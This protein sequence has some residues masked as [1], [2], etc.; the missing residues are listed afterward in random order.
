MDS[1]SGQQ[2]GSF[3]VGELIGAGGM[4]LI[5][6]AFQPSMGRPVA[7]KLLQRALIKQDARFLERFAREAQVAASLTHPHIVPVYDYGEHAGQPYLVMALLEGGSL[8]DR[9]QREGPLDLASSARIVRA[10]GSALDFAHSQGVIHRDVKPDNVVFDLS[11]NP[12]LADFG[13]ARLT[14]Q[15][16]GNLTGTGVV[17]TL[18]YMAPEMAYDGKAGPASDLY[19]LGVTAWE[20]LTAQPLYQAGNPAEMMLAHIQQA[21]PEIHTLR[22]DLPDWVQSA[23]ARALAK[24]A[25]QRYE[26]ASQFGLALEPTAEFNSLPATAPAERGGPYYYPNAF[27]RSLLGATRDAL[28][29]QAYQA[30]LVHADLPQFFESL[31]PNDFRK[32]VT[33]EQVGRLTQALY[34]IYGARG[35]QSVGVRAGADSYREAL[36]TLKPLYRA[37]EALL[38][39][40]APERWLYTGLKNFERIFNTLSDQIVEVS[41]D[42]DAVLWRILRCPLCW[43]WQADQPVCHMAVGNLMAAMDNT[44]GEG[45]YRV[46]ATHCIARG[47]PSG[48]IRV[49]PRE[50]PQE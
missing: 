34:Q 50:A 36:D 35:A 21:I 13:I 41:E 43:G 46:R 29:E 23:L 3:E 15:S 8:A 31:P 44:F 4:A 27:M 1:L 30:V 28:G 19:A 26:N 42:G 2:I 9:I 14:A 39:V 12:Y 24:E 11:G 17:G 5:Y 6:R 25:A 45:R 40:T 49:E 20:M 48:L 37:T 18:A 22:P 32:R 16:T 10:L 33:F 47:D 7:I 38:K